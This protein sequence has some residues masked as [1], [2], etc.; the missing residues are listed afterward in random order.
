MYDLIIKQ[1]PFR[2]K[3]VHFSCN[4]VFLS[5]ES[6]YLEV[7][8]LFNNR[9]F[10]NSFRSRGRH[11]FRF[12]SGDVSFIHINYSWNIL[13]HKTMKENCYVIPHLLYSSSFQLKPTNPMGPSRLRR[14]TDPRFSVSFSMARF[15]LRRISASLARSVDCHGT[16]SSSGKIFHHNQFHY[17]S[18]SLPLCSSSWSQARRFRALCYRSSSRLHIS[19]CLGFLFK[20][21]LIFLNF[22][23][24]LLGLW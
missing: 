13:A 2:K 22:A 5:M 17:Q 8:N 1:C 11:R 4:Y 6:N 3:N 12:K 21:M 15:K 10:C 14:K 7:V 9:F 24:F 23:C 16:L 18:S 19:L 20:L